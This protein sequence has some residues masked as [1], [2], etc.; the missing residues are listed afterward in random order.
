MDT[1][2]LS[3]ILADLAAGRIDTAE[4]NRLIEDLQ[5]APRT[6]APTPD[7]GSTDG[8]AD[9]PQGGAEGTSGGTDGGTPHAGTSS[10]ET[11]STT[12]A[13]GQV[14]GDVLREVF[15]TARHAASRAADVAAEAAAGAAGAAG[16]VRTD[17]GHAE[18]GQQHAAAGAP[19]RTSAGARRVSVR[20]TGKRVR[21]VV[22]P[23]VSGCHVTGEHALRRNG[24]LI[25]VS[26]EGDFRPH[27]GG[28]KLP[29]PFN[30][31]ALHLDALRRPRGNE[32]LIR[33]H[34]SMALDVEVTAGNL[35]VANVPRLGRVRLTAGSATITGF[36]EVEDALVQA[37][38]VQMSGRITTGRSR[39]RVESGQLS[40][41]LD[42]DSNVTVVAAS[43][44]GR[45]SWSGQHS[46]SG[47]Q[48]VMG[49]GSARL[50]V[51]VV[52]GH[53]G[54]QVGQPAADPSGS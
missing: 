1:P 47:D 35:Q 37:A 5:G 36:E 9:A 21:I 13:T 8:S 7:P 3:R 6:Q 53:A 20:V 24:D 28:I 50:D 33:L 12:S 19:G 16:Y 41:K 42:P 44:I 48:V 51:T 34:P 29:S 45:V 22:D 49:N 14:A 26:A 32:L 4:A 27:L 52:M 10:S 17:R 54:V 15:R 11:W 38:V 46:G 23:S 39:I 18:A 40:L 30:L 25:E 31:D 2:D 43:S